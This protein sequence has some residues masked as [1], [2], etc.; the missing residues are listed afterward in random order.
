M[1]PQSL[2]RRIALALA[3]LLVAGRASAQEVFASTSANITGNGPAVWQGWNPAAL[4]SDA[5][6]LRGDIGTTIATGVSSWADQSGHG[7]NA[8][9]PTGGS[10]PTLNTTVCPGG[11]AGLVF[12]RAGAK[13]MSVA[14]FSLVQ[15]EYVWVV[16]KWTSTSSNQYIIDGTSAANTMGLYQ[17][18]NPAIIMTAGTVL[19][20]ASGTPTAFTALGA[21]YSGSASSLRA[22]DTIV[23][24]PSSANT[25]APGGITIGSPEGQAG[26]LYSD[27]D[28]CEI[29]VLNAAPTPDV[30]S[31]LSSYRSS[32]Y[33][34]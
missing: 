21:L 24:S 17:A 13:W 1:T 25:G 2:A 4:P 11:N 9:Q 5:V 15:P 18:A 32:R 22:N 20:W 12:S 6:W 19:S 33:G 31:R 23:I 14:S 30:L 8:S 26:G 7:R 29:V 3:I 34:F 10:Q 28:L 27:A 16:M